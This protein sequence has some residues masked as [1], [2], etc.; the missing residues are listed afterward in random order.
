M[1][2]NAGTKMMTTQYS[3]AGMCVRNMKPASKPSATSV[4]VNSLC[5]GM[6]NLLLADVVE[7]ESY[8]RPS[9]KLR[10]LNGLISPPCTVDRD[11]FEKQ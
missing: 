8:V 9:D 7:D 3:P 5:C 6:N 1:K 2:S 4:Y 11:P 10:H